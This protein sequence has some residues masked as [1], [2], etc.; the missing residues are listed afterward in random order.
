MYARPE[1]FRRKLASFASYGHLDV[2]TNSPIKLPQSIEPVKTPRPDGDETVSA[3]YNLRES[4]PVRDE[5][6][7]DA[8]RA[9]LPDFVEMR[10]PAVASGRISL[11]WRE[12]AFGKPF[13]INELSEG[14]LRFLWLCTI[15]SSEE[16][17]EIL[18]FDEPDVSLH[19]AML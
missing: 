16:L 8:L 4:N 13:Y 11:T 18:V 6:V 10:F 2:G 5:A 14:T 9:V 1:A 15:L 7:E 3:L 19:P 12:G 17:P